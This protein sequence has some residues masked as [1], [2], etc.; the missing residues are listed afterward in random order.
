MATEAG[1]DLLLLAHHRRDQ[2]ETLLLQALR[3]GGVAGLAAMPRDDLREG[4]RWVRPWLDHPREAI[5]AYIAHHGLSYIEDDSNDDP[6][7]A[8]NRLRLQVWPALLA[9]FPQAEASLA[10]SAARLADAL[11]PLKAWEEGALSQLAV[12]SDPAAMQALVW[13]AWSPGVRRESLRRWY[14]R[15][16]GASLSASWTLRL[17]EELPRM[18]EAGALTGQWPEVGLGLYRGCLRWDGVA[19][20]GALGGRP[21]E[22]TRHHIDATGLWPL[23]PWGGALCVTLCEESGVAP[24]RLRRITLKARTGGERFQTGPGRPPRSL[25][26][27]FQ[28]AAVPAWMRHAP[29]VWSDNTLLYVPGLGIDARCWARPGAPQWA[30]DWRWLD[31]G[32]APKLKCGV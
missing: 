15:T 9:A 10:A 26:K 19:S 14:A 2:A 32:S 30:L 4:L 8:R 25:K 1:A 20:R 31:A 16:A 23:P 28:S 18:L 22:E 3:G 11:L 27:Q 17:S 12:P 7:F 6:R 5:E 29:L 13:A 21:L 24:E